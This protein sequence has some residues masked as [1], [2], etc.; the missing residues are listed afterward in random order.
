MP[1]EPGTGRH[2][3]VDFHGRGC[4]Q[5]TARRRASISCGCRVRRRSATWSRRAAPTFCRRMV[6]SKSRRP[7]RHRA[8]AIVALARTTVVLAQSSSRAGFNHLRPGADGKR[9]DTGCAARIRPV[10][11]RSCASCGRSCS[12]TTAH[13]RRPP[14]RVCPRSR[15]DHPGRRVYATFAIGCLPTGQGRMGF[16]CRGATV[17]PAGTAGRRRNPSGIP[18]G[19]CDTKG[20]AGACPVAPPAVLVH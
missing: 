6:L 9:E 12:A 1:V 18:P 19:R 5:S 13:R 2:P 3:G 7:S 10:G 14:A 16:S 11:R 8:P 20:A 15:G 17:A 4:A